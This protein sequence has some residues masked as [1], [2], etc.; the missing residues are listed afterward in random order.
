ME[1]IGLQD[2]EAKPVLKYRWNSDV[3]SELVYCFIALGGRPN[4]VSSEEIS[5]GKF[6]KI[7][8]IERNL[9]KNLFT[10]NF[11]HEYQLLKKGGIFNSRPKN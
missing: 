7:S 2:F 4:A 3:E 11:E 8:E 1:E 10:P 6:W 9:G 5:E